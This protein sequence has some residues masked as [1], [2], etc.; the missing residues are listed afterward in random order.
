L[1]RFNAYESG[2]ECTFSYAWLRWSSQLIQLRKFCLFEEIKRAIWV[3]P[4]TIKNQSI[5]HLKEKPIIKQ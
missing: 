3:N 1:I 2:K 5:N 4:K